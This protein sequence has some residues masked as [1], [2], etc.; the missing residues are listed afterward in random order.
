MDA[1]HATKELRKTPSSET[2]VKETKSPPLRAAKQ[3]EAHRLKEYPPKRK[4]APYLQMPQWVLGVSP[5]VTGDSPLRVAPFDHGPGFAF[6]SGNDLRMSHP[7]CGFLS[8][9]GQ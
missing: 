3:R 9:A 5:Q 4:N 1:L 7:T 2:P 6:C 8:G